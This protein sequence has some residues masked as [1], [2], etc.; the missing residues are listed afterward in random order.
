M[1]IVRERFRDAIYV[2]GPPQ[3]GL[4]PYDFEVNH[5]EEDGLDLTRNISRQAVTTGPAFVLQQAPSSRGTLRY[6]GTILTQSQ[7]DAMKAY[8]DACLTRTVFFRDFTNVEYEVVVTRFNPQR[9]RAAKNP[10]SPSLMH[11]WTYSLEMEVIA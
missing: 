7:Y 6:S 3:V 1:T 5:D 4:A 8:F 10:R 9:R 2:E 11:Y